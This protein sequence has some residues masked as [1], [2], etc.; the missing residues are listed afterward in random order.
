ML[1]PRAAVARDLIPRELAGRGAQVDVL[2]AYRTELPELAGVHAREVFST[3]QDWVTFTS[4]ST[5]RNL[6]AAAGLEALRGVRIASIG[7][8]TSEA[9]R[10]AGLTVAVEARSFT[11]DGLI[12]AILSAQQR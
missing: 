11:L 5:V 1:L 2:E 9:V 8:V 3:P 12:E 7:P 4:A 10:R 6:V